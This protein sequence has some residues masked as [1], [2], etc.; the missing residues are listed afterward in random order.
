MALT[1]TIAQAVRPRD[2]RLKELNMIRLTGSSNRLLRGKIL[3]TKAA[4][5]KRTLLY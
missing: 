3:K 4:G 1:S 5:K 2:W